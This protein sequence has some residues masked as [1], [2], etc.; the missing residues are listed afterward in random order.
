VAFTLSTQT[1]L[2]SE[3]DLSPTRQARRSRLLDVAAQLFLRDGYR[4]TTIEGLCAAADVS[5]ATWYK[6]FPDKER[7]F[8]ELV[9]ERRLAPDQRLLGDLTTSVQQ[10]MAQIQHPRGREGLR[11]TLLRL[12]KASARRR[13]DVFFRLMVEIAFASPALLLAVRLELFDEAA[14]SIEAIDSSLTGPDVAAIVHVV[15]L[16]MHGQMLIGDVPFAHG[17]V[18]EERLASALADM[19]T[20]AL[21]QTAA[22]K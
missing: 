3:P 16:A 6:Y 22:A 2:S 11:A 9:R 19:V 13:N 1:L 21:A 7:L 20:A 4:A 18:N 14:K 10:M 8:L 5:K 12:L 15:F 17:P